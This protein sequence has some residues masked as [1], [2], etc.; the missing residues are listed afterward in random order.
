MWKQLVE[1]KFHQNIE[2]FEKELATWQFF[3][4]KI[5][6]TNGCFDILHLGHLT[7]LMQARDLGHRLVIGLNTDASVQKLKGPQRPV[8]SQE[9]RGLI[10]AALRFVDA[11]V[12]FDEETPENL[13]RQVRPNILVKGSD[14]EGKTIAGAD[15]VKQQGGEVVL[16]DFV[17]GHSTTSILSKI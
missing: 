17:P 1:K 13:I 4:E 7:Y 14:Y 12:L 11:V 5:V 9:A 15:F 10:L 6:F 2:T 16:L 3:N 8:Q